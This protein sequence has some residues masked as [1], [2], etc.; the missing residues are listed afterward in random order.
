MKARIRAQWRN[1]LIVKLVG[2]HVKYHVMVERLQKEWHT[3]EFDT[4][5]IGNGYFVCNFESQVECRRMFTDGSYFMFDHFLHVQRWRPN[6]KADQAI[7]KTMVVWVR[8]PWL[9]NEYFDEEA[10][11]IVASVLGRLIKLD[12]ATTNASRGRFARVCIEIDTEKPLLTKVHIN[13]QF[14]HIEYEGL[15]TICYICG[16]I[17]HRRE[18]CIHTIGAVREPLTV[19]S[20]TLL[21]SPVVSEPS[22]AAVSPAIDTLDS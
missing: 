13:R 2:Y 8:F 17:G 15:P 19:A 4:L 10:V 18:Q 6:F 11:C 9:S 7:I 16:R 12:E 21:N 1:A 5:Y 22:Q 14:V 20:P 3:S